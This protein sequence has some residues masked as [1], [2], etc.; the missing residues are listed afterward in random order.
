MPPSWRKTSSDLTS[1]VYPVNVGVG[2]N[3]IPGNMNKEYRE[4]LDT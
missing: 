2:M 3:G 4:Y 1:E